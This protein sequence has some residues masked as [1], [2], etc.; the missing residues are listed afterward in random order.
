M[1][2]ELERSD[3]YRCKGLLSA[4]VNVE[5][6]AIIEGNNTGRVFVDNPTSPRSGLV[7]LGNNDGSFLIGDSTTNSFNSE[8][9]NFILEDK[10]L[11]LEYFEVAGIH[12]L[13]NETILTIFN[14]KAIQKWTQK[15]YKI[16]EECYV[17]AD[18]PKIEENYQTEKLT[19]DI[20][21]SNE[22]TNSK[23]ISATILESWRSIDE[24]LQLGIGY[25]VIYNHEI[26][27][28]CFSNFVTANNQCIH[29]ETN[30]AHRGKQLAKKLAHLFVHECF[31]HDL[32]PYWD[33]TTTNVAS[34][35]VARSVGFVEDF[36]YDVYGFEL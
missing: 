33:C 31:K 14:E 35:A 3:F 26:V 12:P 27:S 5:V 18:S 13:W 15:V 23:E 20:L 10:S 16:V 21:T 28:I 32:L 4:E 8:L 11:G 36:W 34:V 19:K 22:I 1:I 24:F 29:I 17:K 7:L 30:E 9:K 25:C 6:N 2:Y